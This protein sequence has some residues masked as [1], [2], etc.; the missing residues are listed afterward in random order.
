MAKGQDCAHPGPLFP[1]LTGRASGVL[2]HP[3]MLP[4]PGGIG[5]LGSAAHALPDLLHQCG[6]SYWQV[7]PLGPT[8][9]GDSPYQCFSAFAG[10]PYLIDLAPLV[11]SCL[12]HAEEI[13]ALYHLPERRVDYGAQYTL[14]REIL[15]IAAERFSEEPESLAEAYGDLEEFRKEHAAWLEPYAAFQALKTLEG[16]KSWLQ[17]SPAHRDYKQFLRQKPSAEFRE[18][19]CE[20]V[21]LQ[22]V[23]FGQWKRLRRRANEAGIRIVGDLPIFV[24]LDSA[25]VWSRPELF[26]LGKDLRP[27][28]V[29]GVPPDYFSATGQLWG[30]PLYA[31]Q[32]MQEDDFSWW[33]DRLRLNFDLYDVIRLDHFRGFESYYAIPGGARDAMK[34]EWVKAPGKAFFEAVRRHFPDGKMILEDLGEIT[35]EVEALKDFTGFPGTA[36]LQ[37]AFDAPENPYLPHNL[38]ANTVCYPGTHDNNTSVGWYDEVDEKTRDFLRRYLRVSGQEVGWDLIRACLS[39]VASLAILPVQDILGLGTEARFNLPGHPD[40]NWSWRLAPGHLEQMVAESG[41]YLR[42]LNE[43]YGRCRLTS[44]QQ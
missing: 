18:L 13:E 20:Q 40:G 43:L 12:L 33:M 11:R 2:L 38:S 31:W 15:S 21:F 3:T 22:Y 16:G 24:S 32:T 23:F 26:E 17:W 27:L 36:V 7:C 25:D 8:G 19:A 10:N 4:G 44:K 9:F 35:P 42:E 28:R 41:D 5:S 39:S 29:A 34:G 30:N 14:R 1:P 6:F 37:F